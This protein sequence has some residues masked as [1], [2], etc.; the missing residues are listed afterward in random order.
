MPGRGISGHRRERRRSKIAVLSGGA[1][2][3]LL[4]LRADGAL[5]ITV[6]SIVLVVVAVSAAYRSRE[7]RPWTRA[8]KA[9]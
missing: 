8:G 9:R 5:A 4:V 3:A 7:D 6:A 1:A 2:G